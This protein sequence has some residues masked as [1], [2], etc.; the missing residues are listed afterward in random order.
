MVQWVWSHEIIHYVSDH[1]L[2]LPVEFID[3]I[4]NNNFKI[5]IPADK[6]ELISHVRD[7]FPM[8]RDLCQISYDIWNKWL[9][10]KGEKAFLSGKKIGLVRKESRSEPKDDV[11]LMDLL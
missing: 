7:Q 2:D 11:D 4:K 10:D 6:L 9:E 8:D 5:S 3:H 1:N